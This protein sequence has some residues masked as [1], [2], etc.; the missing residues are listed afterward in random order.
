MIFVQR[1]KIAIA[2]AL[3]C[4]AACSPVAAAT[5]GKRPPNIVL[6]L[7]D[8]LGWADLGCYGNRFNETPQIDALAARSMRMTDAYAAGAVCSPTRASILSGQYQARFG[9]TAHIPGH[10]KPYAL[11]EEPPNAPHL[12]LDIVTLPELL[13]AAG[14]ATAHYGKWHLGPASH[15]PPQQGFDDSVVTSGGH[16]A[17]FRTEPE[18]PA[19]AGQPLTHYLTDQALA[20]LE[21]NRDQPCY[22]QIWHYAVHIR[23]AAEEALIEKYRRKPKVEGY[24]CNPAYAAL[25]ETADQSIGRLLAGLERLGLSDQTLLV[26]TSDNGGLTTTYSGGETITV[27][28]PLRDEKGS[29]YEGGIRVP[30]IVHWPGRIAPG[31]AAHEPVI[32]VDLLPTFLAAA[33][34]GDSSQQPRDGVNLMPLLTGTAALQPRA[35]YWHYPHYHHSRPSGALRQGP[36]KLIEFFDTGELEL[37]DLAQ[38]MGETKN[39]VAERSAEASALQQRLA[40]WREQV[41]ARMPKPNPNY[42]AARADEFAS[43]KT[44]RPRGRGR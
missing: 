10:W 19:P 40:A 31:S 1:I 37:Y 32:S 29:L 6:V 4:A 25:L 11:L 41:E 20:F 22:V 12:P 26:F 34:V 2:T 43:R 3:L 36:L 15:Y 42:D 14:Y 39:L 44:G 16:I 18:R 35:L 17:P 13:S 30:M 24:P 27:N 23:L 8:D 21:A 7:M 5:D 38:D 28:T 33:G 9:L